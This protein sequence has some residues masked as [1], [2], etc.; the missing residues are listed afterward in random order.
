[1]KDRVIE[2]IR[3][4]LI[5]DPVRWEQIQ[6]QA[7]NLPAHFREI[8]ERKRKSE[9]PVIHFAAYVAND[10]MYGMH[11]VFC[12]MQKRP[13][14]WDP[15]VVIIPDVSR[16]IL[17]Q[18]QTYRRTRDFFVKLY[19]ADAVLDGWDIQM[20]R[21]IDFTD[22]FD[23]I[24]F[25]DPYDAMAPEVHSIRH[26]SAKNVLPVY[27]NYGYDIGFYTMYARLKGPELNFVWKYFTET[28]YSQADC[29]TLQII[30]G[31]NVVLT[32]YAKMDAYSGFPPKKEGLRKK[33]LITAHHLI[34]FRELPLSCFM[35]YYK[36]IPELP[37]L[38]PNVDFVFRPHPLLFARMINEKIWTADQVR[39]YLDEI[40]KA[41][42]EYSDGGEYLSLFAECDAIVN[43]CGSFTLEWLFTG[44]PGCFVFNEE[45][46]EEHLTTQMK[47]AVKRYRIAR[48]SED[49]I[50]FI[51]DV[52]DGVYPFRHEMDGWVRE[53]IAVNYPHAAKKILEEMDILEGERSWY[54]NRM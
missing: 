14:R 15:K 28:V 39:C 24:Y 11:D 42:I 9:D 16:G 52:A 2:E 38:F 31:K 4:N 46:K 35:L 29:E 25:A 7:E 26:A 54:G 49:I 23:I 3:Q 32:G 12:L 36:L 20:D 34:N 37:E 6:K 27:V 13:E 51:T 43:D 48:S 10:A 30:R 33:I 8:I 18:E 21:Y 5:Y 1:M 53:N 22:R 17:H 41:G 47:E 19:G 40:R 44:R 50:G 45:L